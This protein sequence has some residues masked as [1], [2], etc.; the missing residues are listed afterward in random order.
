VSNREGA[1]K[2]PVMQLPSRR[3]RTL[4]VLILTLYL[5]L[6]LTYALTTPAFEASDE[7]WHY[8]MVRHLADGN[9]LPVQV[10]DPAQAGPWNQEASQPPLYYYLG[11]AL[12]FWIDQSDME[13]VRWLN[14]HVDTG[15]ITSDGNINLAI[16]DP[17]N[18]PWQ[19]TLL[20]VRLVRLFSVMLGAGTV[21]LTYLIALEVAPGRPEVALTAAALNAFLPMFLFISG[22]VNND[23][24]AILLASMAVWLMVRVVTKKD[25]NSVTVHWWKWMIIGIVIGLAVMT[26]EGT[27]GLIP[28]ALGT[29]VVSAWQGTITRRETVRATGRQRRDEIA[30]NPVDTEPSP[31]SSSVQMNRGGLWSA[32]SALL[33]SLTMMALPILAIA[34]WWYY[35]NIVLYGDWL[36]W[37]AFI[38]VLGQ[39]A[40]PASLAQ[41]WGERHGFLMSYWGLFG[42][43]NVPMP[44]WVYTVLNVTLV[45]SV[46]GFV[47]Y[48]VRLLIKEWSDFRVSTE[49]WLA[50]FLKPVIRN[51]G[52][53]VILLFSS[54]VVYGLIQWATT[55]WSSQGRLVF[56][57]ISALSILMALGLAGIADAISDLAGIIYPLRGK[58]RIQPYMMT[59]VIIFLLVI[60]AVTPFLWIRPS[61]Q[62]PALSRPLANRADLAFGDRMRLSGYEVL[63]DEPQP[64]DTIR[65]LL[66]WEVMREMDR[67]WSVFVHLNDPVLGRPIA[68]RD[69]F[70]G[71]GLLATRLLEPGRR[72]VDE[73]VLAIPPTAFAP[74]E[75]ELVVGL[76]DY[77]TGERLAGAGGQDSAT[78]GTIPLT[79][80]EG[81]Y[82]NPVSIFFEQGLELIGFEVEPRRTVPSANIEVKTYWR[83]T[84]PLPADFTFFA[85]IIGQDTSRF[86]AADVVPPVP[87]SDWLPGQSYEVNLPL[88]LDQSTPPDAY[89]LIIG[90]YT[91]TPEGGFDRLQLV[92]PDGRLTDDF[93]VLTQVKVDAP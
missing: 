28:L 23:N 46:I 77:S 22:S 63:F 85:Q 37:N 41:L 29:A 53:I 18:N 39:R 3:D 25:P 71:R 31:S 69:M 26:K 61:Y 70:A 88:T 89:P 62:P 12:T 66:E 19:G 9:P 92:T 43:V 34:G 65:V 49:W 1:A 76:Y 5:L 84:R 54:A 91:R 24:L 33:L 17:D 73:Y 40:H 79:A 90:L 56:T 64:G 82:P 44:P 68:Q 48:F 38:A 58:V 13:E 67:D 7:L 60:A 80:S 2:I 55:T 4:L 30:D 93:L 8:P 21:F 87:S 51:F 86:A 78:L 59:I 20:A 35:R 32:A 52:L 15:V 50:R 6:G 42:G 11:A 14:P 36:G 75:L 57:A 27:L 47:Y 74:A 81:P 72:L 83:P 45:I 10:F 16:H